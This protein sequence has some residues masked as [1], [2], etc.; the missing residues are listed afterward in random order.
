LLILQC[1]TGG[2]FNSFRYL[3][4]VFF[5]TTIQKKEALGAVMTIQTFGDY[6]RWHHYIHAIIADGIFTDNGAFYL[7]PRADMILIKGEWGY[8]RNE[9]H[10]LYAVITL[11]E[12][13]Q[14]KSSS[15]EIFLD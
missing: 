5:Q 14:L 10:I 1:V 15:F 3:A 2:L 11:T 8:T 9:K 4:A 12:I 7:M 6:A 13:G